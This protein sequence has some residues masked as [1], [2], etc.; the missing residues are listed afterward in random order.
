MPGIDFRQLRASV[1]MGEVLELLGFVAWR[2]TGEQVRGI[3]PLHADA[4]AAGK[5]RT[6]SAHLARHAFQCFKCRAQGNPLDL[7]SRA[8]KQPLYEAAVDLCARLHKEVPW[9]AK[10]TEKRNS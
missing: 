6:F 10:R 3:C 5:Q 7:W 8:S 1:S 9:L 2:R 4:S